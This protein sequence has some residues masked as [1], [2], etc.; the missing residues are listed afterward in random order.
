MSAGDDSCHSRWT[1]SSRVLRFAAYDACQRNTVDLRDAIT[2][3]I[4]AMIDVCE[5]KSNEGL[6]RTSKSVNKSFLDLL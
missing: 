5:S 4:C 6:R 3:G 2:L 1:L